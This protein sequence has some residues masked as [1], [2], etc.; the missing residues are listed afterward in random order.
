MNG[1]MVRRLVMKDWYLHRIA[2]ALMVGGVMVGLVMSAAPGESMP[3]MGLNLILCLFIAMTFYLPLSTVLN[4]RTEK[5]L[6]FVMSLP[7][8]PADYTMAKI[9][10]SV[11][12]YMLPL[13]A[14]ALAV[15]L[16]LKGDGSSWPIAVGFAHVILVG[17][18]T[19]F[20]F[21]LGFAL[22]T[23][24]MGWTVALIVVM[25]FMFGNVF[26]QLV[27]KLPA[28]Q[29]FLAGIADRGSAY[30]TALGI[31]ALLIVAILGLTFYAQTRKRDF[32]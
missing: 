27:P 7:A 10:S 29:R 5:T 25:M 2:I 13:L 4:E 9:V 11:L 24:S 21:V 18:L 32:L 3:V 14:T 22:I 28:A 6:S 19:L 1:L 20:S 16:T 26:I 8:S 30:Y 17:M 12:L 15:T 31:E 23:E